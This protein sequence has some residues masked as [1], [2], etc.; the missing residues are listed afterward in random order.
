MGSLMRTLLAVALGIS[1]AAAVEITVSAEGGNATNGHQYGFL[2]EDI[3]NSGDGGLYAELIRNRAFQ[4]SYGYPSTLDA[5]YPINGAQLA[6]QDLEIPLSDA[7]KTSVNVATGESDGQV[8][9]LNVG[10]WG[11][12]VRVQKYKGSF[13]V[14][15]SYDGDFTVSLQSNLTSDTFGSTK[16]KSQSTPDA[17]TEHIIEFSPNKTAPNSNNTFAITFDAAGATDG[18]LDFNLISLFPPTF[19]NRENGMRIDIVEAL[20]GFHPTLFRIPGGNMLEGRTNTSW[21]D[22]KDTLG[23]LKD[24]PGFAGVWDYPQTHGL[25]LLEYLQFAED[26]GMELG[27]CLIV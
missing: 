9:L 24:R 1:S 11:M 17:W 7:L 23:P 22:W 25:G 16:I 15:G 3:N 20:E 14:K 21:W 2:H 10:Y 4:S 26:L 27:K 19:K 5:W 6:L 12:D 8:G 18:S 13:W